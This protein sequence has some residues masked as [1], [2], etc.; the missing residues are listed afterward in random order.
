MNRLFRS[1]ELKIPPLALATVAGALIWLAAIALPRLRLDWPG[2]V[3]AALLLGVAGLA[4]CLAGVAAFRRAQTTVDPMRPEHTRVLV[5]RGI[6]HY[7]RNPMYVGFALLLCGWAT[8]TGTAAG[9]AI[10]I[11]YVL[12]LDRFQVRPEERILQ[13]HFGAQ[14]DAYRSSVRRWI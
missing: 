8:W 11:T 9:L 6:Y 7:T 13:H 14:Y 10:A 1:L 2:R 3:P 5:V 4:V 12:Y